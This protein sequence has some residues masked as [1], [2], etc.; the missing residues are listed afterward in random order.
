MAEALDQARWVED[1]T[2]QCMKDQG[3]DYTPALPTIQTGLIEDY[4]PDDRDWISSHGYGVTNTNSPPTTVVDTSD[5]GPDP[6]AAYV[7]SLS[8]AEKDAY[9]NTLSYSNPSPF[10]P[11]LPPLPESKIGNYGNGCHGWAEYQW[12]VEHPSFAPWSQGSQFQPLYDAID[13]FYADLGMT[14]EGT[15]EPFETAWAQCMAAAG[16]P[17]YTRQREAR[18]QF[19]ADYN[20]VATS[21][22]LYPAEE[23]DWSQKEIALALD[24][25]NC[26]ESTN[27]TAQQQAS[28]RAAEE[29]F[30]TDHRSEFAA[31][32][33]AAEQAQASHH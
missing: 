14:T 3:F 2:A 23:A 16:R 27:Y 4:R 18:D 7:A 11:D 13:T 17:G 30:V 19:M 10:Y 31:L 29:Q 24:D 25:L 1:K 22:G 28:Q 8:P 12:V 32:K 20:A 33:L 21:T 5:S 6:N 9:S 15:P 26:R